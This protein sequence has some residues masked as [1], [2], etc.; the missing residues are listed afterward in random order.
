[1]HDPR[2]RCNTTRKY[3]PDG[4]PSYPSA[5]TIH[6]GDATH[7]RLCDTASSILRPRI[8]RRWPVRSSLPIFPRLM[9]VSCCLSARAGHASTLSFTL[10][11]TDCT[12]WWTLKAIYVILQARCSIRVVRPRLQSPEFEGFIL[13]S[14]QY[15]GNISRQVYLIISLI[16]I[17]ENRDALP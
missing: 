2:G 10:Q 11:L 7:T 6:G 5:C 12:Y 9:H 16:S 1:M 13:Q 4:Y 17:F 15:M 8:L 3:P 14:V